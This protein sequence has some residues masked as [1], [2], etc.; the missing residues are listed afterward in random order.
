MDTGIS[1][2]ET[3]LLDSDT[4]GEAI[5]FRLTLRTIQDVL[6]HRVADDRL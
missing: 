4:I 3:A 5:Q 2:Q 1:I 6:K